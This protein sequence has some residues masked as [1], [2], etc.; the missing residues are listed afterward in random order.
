MAILWR[1]QTYHEFFCSTCQRWFTEGNS[2]D[3]PKHRLGKPL[4]KK[5]DRVE[6]VVAVKQHCAHCCNTFMLCHDQYG[7][8]RIIKDVGAECPGLILFTE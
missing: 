3:C 2:P 4:Y 5:I 6:T 1:T 8:R 7:Q